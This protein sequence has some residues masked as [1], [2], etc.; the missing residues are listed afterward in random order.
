[1][2][3]TSE[4]QDALSW[5]GRIMQMN[6]GGFNQRRAWCWGRGGRCCFTL[7]LTWGLGGD[8]GRHGGGGGGGGGGEKRGRRHMLI[9]LLVLSEEVAASMEVRASP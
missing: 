9:V 2:S 6:P 8:V 3:G 5:R 1:M 4:R 7:R